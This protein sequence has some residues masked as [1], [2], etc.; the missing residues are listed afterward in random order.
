MFTNS[1]FL[2]LENYKQKYYIYLGFEVS[3]DLYLHTLLVQ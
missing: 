2:I 1:I 3:I